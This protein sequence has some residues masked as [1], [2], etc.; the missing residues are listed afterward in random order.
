MVRHQAKRNGKT[1]DIS[2]PFDKDPG[3]AWARIART[4]TVNIHLDQETYLFSRL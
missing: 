2:I 1:M 3:A 4:R